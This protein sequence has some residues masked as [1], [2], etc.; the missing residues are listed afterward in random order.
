MIADEI[1]T[2]WEIIWYWMK[3][4]GWEIFCQDGRKNLIVQQRDARMSVCPD[5]LEQVEANPDLMDQVLVL[6]NVNSRGIQFFFKQW[7]TCSEIC[8]CVGQTNFFYR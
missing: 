1:N 6:S 3:N 2:N 4:W 8:M 5:L 7:A